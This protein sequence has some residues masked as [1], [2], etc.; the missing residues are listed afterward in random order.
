MGANALPARRWWRFLAVLAVLGIVAAACGGNDSG[1]EVGEGTDAAEA[2]AAEGD[3]DEGETPQYG[4]KVLFARES[5]TSNPFTPAAMTC[6]PACHHV[7]RTF[8]DPLTFLGEDDEAHPFLLESIEPNEDFTVWTLTARDGITFHDDTP[9]DA[10]AVMDH[11]ERMRA[12]PLIGRSLINIEDHVKV[13]DRTVELTMTEP[14]ATFPHYLAI[15]GGYVASPTWLAAVDAGEADP[16]EPVGTGPFVFAEYNP[17]DNLRVTRNAD[18]WLSD[19]DGNQYPYLDEI[20]FVVREEDLS[21][22]RALIAGDVDITHTDK[23]ES[24]LT[25]RDAVEAGDIE[26]FEVTDRAETTYAMISLADP[27]APVSDVRIRRAMAHATDQQVRSRARTGGLFELADGPFPPGT[28]GHLDDSGWPEFDPDEARALVD[29]YKAD[30]GVD[31]VTIEFK[32][33]ADPDN[34]ATVELLQQL[35]S[36]VGIDVEIVQLEQGELI[37][38][39]AL[40]DFQVTTWRRH[41]GVNPELERVYWHSETASPVGE[42]GI[43]FGRFED[44]VIDEALDELRATQ[45]AAT[46]VAAAEAI[47]ARFAEQVYNLWFDWISWSFPHQAR[48]HGVADTD[49]PARRLPVGGQRCRLPRWHRDDPALGRRRGGRLMSGGDA[50]MRAYAATLPVPEFETTAFTP[51]DKPLSEARVAIVTSAALHRPDDERFAEADTGFRV[52]DRADRDLVMGHWSPN[53]DHT[54]FQLDLNV[55][56]P[57]DRLEELAADGVIGDVAPRHF[58]FAG[59]QPD[60]VSE[61]RLDTGPACAAELAADAVDVVLLTPV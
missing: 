51:L 39:I 25:L 57:I 3:P 2:T 9:F 30:T 50:A 14:W 17:G 58:A 46:T 19:A 43:N 18:Y 60:T 27:D 23:G 7:V 55:V 29:D 16:T 53:F 4:G 24:V 15:S 59:N 49:R 28:P 31:D 61:L 32:T 12:A 54:G 11:V 8:Y 20:E 44:E 37:R 45:D 26:M 40:G 56:H 41:G 1:G 34:R 36:D 52:L 5:E 13:D 35:W 42:L 48:V 22:E 21:R 33:N 6:D 38:S 47:N 10:D